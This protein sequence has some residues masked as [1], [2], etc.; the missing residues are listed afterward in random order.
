MYDFTVTDAFGGG[1]CEATSSGMVTADMSACPEI[2]RTSTNDPTSFDPCSCGDPLNFF[3][4]MNGNITF[5]HDFV[6]VTSMTGETWEVSV[7]SAQAYS[8]EGVTNIMVGDL[9]TETMPG[10]GIYRIDLFHPPGVGFTMTV[11]RTAGGGPFPLVEGSTCTACQ[12]IP[13][14]GQ[15]GLILLSLLVLTFGVV[16]IRK[17]EPGLVGFGTVSANDKFNLPFNKAVFSKMLIA[18]ML[19]LAAIFAVSIALVMK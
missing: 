3:D 4:P 11:D 15:W 10:S 14:L 13:T 8:D 12:Q 19:G 5:F 18:V 9:L 1:T 17:Q 2:D 6:E 7:V 16:A